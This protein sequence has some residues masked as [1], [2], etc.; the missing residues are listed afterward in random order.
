MIKLIKKILKIL[1][2]R[3]INKI[4]Q[5]IIENND[6]IN[7]RL[8]ELFKESEKRKKTKDVQMSLD[9]VPSWITGAKTL[10]EK[11]NRCVEKVDGKQDELSTA[12][13]SAVNSGITQ[14]KVEHYDAIPIV[15]GNPTESVTDN[16]TKIKIGDTVYKISKYQ[17][18]IY[19]STGNAILDFSLSSTSAIPIGVTELKNNYEYYKSILLYSIALL[20]NDTPV[21]ISYIGLTGDGTLFFDVTGYNYSNIIAIPENSIT[22]DD[23]TEL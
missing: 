3:K 16:L 7:D 19:I 22:R 10:L 5:F 12:Q 14:A 11:I 13:L 15:V 9:Y 6:M 18:N 8:D 21:V 23:V 17:H 1:K 2:N 4:I 20:N